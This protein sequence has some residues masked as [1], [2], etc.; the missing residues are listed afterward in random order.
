MKDYYRILQVSR[1]AS[2]DEI[3]RSYRKLVLLYH[4]DR[5]SA[6]SASRLIREIN[7]AYDVLGDDTRRE[8]YNYRYDRK[9]A[10]PPPVYKK[11]P[12]APPKRARPPRYYYQKQTYD[13]PV[14]GRIS[15]YISAFVL[16]YCLLLCLDY[17]LTKEYDNVHVA[18]T[19]SFVYRSRKHGY[20]YT[21][22]VIHSHLK[23]FEVRTTDGIIEPGNHL[24]LHITYIFRTVRDCCVRTH[25]GCQAIDVIN[26][27]SP[28]FFAVLVAIGFS[29]VPQLTRSSE[30]RILST[31]AACMVFCIVVFF[32]LDT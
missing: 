17:F 1:N 2:A 29:L 32:Q 24:T 4:P 8:Q 10:P 11:T 18:S 28:I 20:S 31:I 7:E 12:A 21:R 22:Y 23:K 19:E 16:A 14:L 15:K 9:D 25:T 3:K 13:F 6:P 30:Q 26:I 27:Y 5:N